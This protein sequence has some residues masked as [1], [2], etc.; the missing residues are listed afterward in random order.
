MPE[1]KAPPK[2]RN[3]QFGDTKIDL[4]KSDV[5]HASR[6]AHAAAEMMAPSK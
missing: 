4:K 6:Q 2:I 1:G 5:S 3:L